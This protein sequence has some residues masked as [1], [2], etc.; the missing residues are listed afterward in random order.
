[1]IE[2]K[3][4]SSLISSFVKELASESKA[5]FGNLEAEGKQLL[6]GGF[7][8][9]LTAQSGKYS[10]L[11]TLLRGNTPAYLYDIYF[12]LKLISEEETVL[13]EKI[14]T[15]FGKTNYVTL[16]GDAGSGKSTLVK[17]LFLNSIQ[18]QFRIPV[19]VELRYLNVSDDSFLG[20]I[21]NRILDQEIAHS[22]RILERMLTGG[23]FVFFLD[24][25]DELNADVKSRVV[26]EIQEFSQL[27][28]DN[29]F[30][31]TSR[32]YSDIEGLQQFSNYKVK[33][34]SRE[35]NEISGFIYK[36]LPNELEIAE[37][38]V[39]SIDTSKS[40]YIQSFLTNPLLLSLYILTFQ[41]FAA[42]PEKKFIFYRRV[43]QALF[44]EHDSKTKL[45]FVR[46]RLSGLSQEQFEHLLKAFC[47]VSYFESHFSWD[48][49]YAA[50]QLK[51]IKNRAGINFTVEKAIR[52]LKSSIALWTEDNGLYSFAHRSLQEYFA[53]S[54]V[55]ELDASQNK[56]VYQ[57]LIEILSNTESFTE[58]E[59]FLS[60]LE[61]L[62]PIS[63]KRYFALPLLGELLRI[64]GEDHG[65]KLGKRY[66]RFLGSKIVARRL[67]VN[68]EDRGFGFI[69]VQMFYRKGLFKAIY[70]HL[71]HTRK[72]HQLVSG[73]DAE[74]GYHGHE[75]YEK[76]MGNRSSLNLLANSRVNKSWWD[77]NGAAVVELAE[78][79]R[80]HVR[81][82]I[83]EIN[84]FLDKEA[85]FDES[86]VDMI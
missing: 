7:S 57:K 28:D 20:Y 16:I 49:S 86:F 81:N 8:K 14:E 61:E 37:K 73:M 30:L 52:D 66:L 74:T 77:A 51:L 12:P 2:E 58:T 21:C 47:F 41:S 71:E 4:I 17:H 27:Y 43:I 50:R 55:S 65:E 46:E 34:L 62:D 68:K 9:Y 19:I 63:F 54:F 36:Q 29:F 44:S 18:T 56:R 38:I 33:Q 35:E 5:F 13:T 23:R 64:I 22:K 83:E 6:R 84:S 15:V 25:Y 10:H 53:A 48:Y 32:P 40:D 60:L 59:N 31:I 70:F 42:I 72:L 67:S 85:S 80:K 69:D 75:F 76:I 39:E 82:E 26:S 45:G 11:K 24:G 3:L 78:E 1:M 79:F